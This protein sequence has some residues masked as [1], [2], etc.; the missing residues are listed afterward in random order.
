[1][2]PNEEPWR[3]DSVSLA[4]V[5]RFHLADLPAGAVLAIWAATLGGGMVLLAV[6][7]WRSARDAPSTW[8]CTAA[9]WLTAMFFLSPM[10]RHYYLA[11]AFPALVVV[12]NA[13]R[14]E[15][16]RQGGGWTAGARFA[17]LTLWAWLLGVLS[18]G[19]DVARWYGLHLAVLALLLAATA[20]AWRVRRPC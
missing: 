1:M 15:R 16:I 7:T 13:L 2:R 19:W 20:W 5:P 4:A 3:I 6:A 12:W 11:L 9:C 17:R 8:T 18:L 14:Q 10:T